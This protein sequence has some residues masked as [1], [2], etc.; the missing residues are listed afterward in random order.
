MHHSAS[1]SR[2]G[3]RGL[4]ITRRLLLLT[5]LLTAAA[6]WAVDNQDRWQLWLAGKPDPVIAPL[7]APKESTNDITFKASWLSPAS[8]FAYRI[9]GSIMPRARYKALKSVVND[10]THPLFKR[11]KT[12]AYQQS[13]YMMVVTIS[14]TPRENPFAAT[15]VTEIA[16][17]E[18]VMDIPVTQAQFQRLLTALEQGPWNSALR[19]EETPQAFSESNVTD[20][21]SLK[22]VSVYR[23]ITYTNAA[24]ARVVLSSTGLEANNAQ[25]NRLTQSR[26]SISSSPAL[27]TVLDELFAPLESH[28]HDLEPILDSKLPKAV[29]KPDGEATPTSVGGPAS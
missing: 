8:R 17:V 16:P 15:P 5:L 13:D 29:T 4:T 27:T 24:G 12:K 6:L 2:G 20:T 11:T 9:E 28:Y 25:W 23:E 7:L 26:H 22:T 10:A 21:T 19:Y 14:R 18:S 1:Y 3:S